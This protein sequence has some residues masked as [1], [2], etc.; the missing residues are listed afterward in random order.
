MI[1][2]KTITILTV[3]IMLFIGGVV[4][5]TTGKVYNTSEGLVLRGSA[6]KSGEPLATVANGTEVEILEDDGQWYKVRVDGKEGYLFAEYVDII[7][8]QEETE[9]TEEISENTEPTDSSSITQETKI[10]LLPTMASTSIATIPADGTITVEKTVGN[11][12]YVSY[13]NI[14]GWIRANKT[15]NV[16]VEESE[17]E[18]EEVVEEETETETE[19]ETESKPE[20]TT[21]TEDTNLSFTQ[22]YINS[23]SVN[24]RKEPN[25]SS[26]VITTLL[27]NTGVTITAQTDEWYKVTYGDYTGYI[28]KSLV[29]DKP[30]E[31]QSTTTSSR[32]SEPRTAPEE[33]T[34]SVATASSSSSGTGTEIAAFA[35]QYLGYSYVYGGTNPS[36]GFDCSGFTQYVYSSF[37]YSLGGR[38]ASSQSQSGTAVSRDNLQPGDLLVFNNDPGGAIG[39]VGIYIG[40]GMMVHAANPRRG[41]AT[42]TINSGYYNTY[43]YTARRI[44]N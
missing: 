17:E 7:E 37:G 2:L 36:S 19:T 44:A 39:H 6:S 20:E 43:Y 28:H 4:F 32:S 16:K 1:K 25:K 14:K 26:D 18:P 40:D 24:V 33:E 27:L 10:H 35:K 15:E 31:T 23:S 21:A 22:G 3:T 5:A 8:E 34:T 29:S 30:T 41:V 9:K 38:G 42:D 13:E 11:W 12:N